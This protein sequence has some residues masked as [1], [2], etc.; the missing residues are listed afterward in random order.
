MEILERLIRMRGPRIVL[1]G[2]R[3]T[4]IITMFRVSLLEVGIL[5][6]W[7]SLLGV[8]GGGKDAKPQAA[9]FGAE[10]Y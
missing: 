5:R 9:L 1:I 4:V 2:V 8:E 3:L 7:G 10:V 6:R